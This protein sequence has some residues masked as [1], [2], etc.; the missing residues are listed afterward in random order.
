MKFMP[1]KIS[2]L[3]VTQNI[4]WA[5]RKSYYGRRN[6]KKGETDSVWSW[7]PLRECFS[8]SAE[9]MVA[10]SLKCDLTLNQCLAPSA[11]FVGKLWR[12]SDLCRDVE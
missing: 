10:V 7:E 8:T 3:G 6:N 1:H 5:Q 12:F 9:F 11:D 2:T 4:F